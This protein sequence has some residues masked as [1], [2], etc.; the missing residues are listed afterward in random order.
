MTFGD[1][2][3]FGEDVNDYEAYPA[4]LE[5]LLP[6]TEVLNFGVH[7]Y[8]HDQMLLYF[9]EEGARYHP[10]VVVLGFLGLDM[11]RNI[12]SFRDYAKPRF[13]LL[14]G[15]L[16][17]RN[18]PVPRPKATATAERR[19]SRF[20]DLLTMIGWGLRERAQEE[21]AR[22]V[23]AAI[24]HEFKR[25]VEAAGA[26]LVI[27]YLPTFGELKPGDESDGERFISAFCGDRGVTLVDLRP[28]FLERRA[29]GVQLKA[30]GHWNRTEHRL[31]AEGLRAA[32]E[33]A[34]RLRDRSR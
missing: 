10:D 8:G 17:L 29:A 23:T 2:F 30:K 15:R 20:V 7:G 9:Q 1:S 4:Q 34:A 22:R 18:T 11:V 13:D 21:A 3:T 24:L 14:D 31:A 12:V 6:G 27:A 28:Y 16:V 5:D 32:V 25:G 19:R 26:R 33:Q